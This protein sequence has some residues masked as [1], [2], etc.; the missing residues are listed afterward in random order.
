MASEKTIEERLG[1]LRAVITSHNFHYYV[2]DAP[3]IQDAEYDLIFR[4]LQQL[5]QQYPHLIT[6]DSPT[7]RVGAPPLKAFAQLAHE[8]PMLSLANAFSDEEVI[9]FDRR[10]REA[11]D[12]KK[13]DYAV[14]PKFDGLAVSLMYENGMLVRGATRGNGYT[15]EDITLNLRTISSIPLRLPVVPARSRFEVRGEVVMLKADF[16]QL[17]QRQQQKGEKIF[18]NPRNAAAGSLR[19]LDSRVTATRKLTFFAYDIGMLRNHQPDFLEHSAV[20]AYLASQQ[21]RVAQQNRIVTGADALLACYHEMAASRSTLPYEID[22]V[23][24]KVN[25]LAQQETLGYVSRAPRFAIAHKFPAQEASTELLAI[26]IQ[27]G[28]TGALTPVARLAPVFVGGVTVTNATLHNEDEIQRKQIMIGDTVIV[29]RAGD[30]IP[31]VVAAIPEHRPADAQSFVMPD[32]CPICDSRAV[33]LPGEAVTRCTGGLYCPAQRKQALWHFASRSAMDIDGLGEKLIDQLVERK[34]V[35]TPADLYKLDV[36]TLAK[37]ERMAEKSAHNLVTA[38]ERSKHTTLSRFIYALGIR[39]VGEATA[40]ALASHAGELNVLMKMRAD[41][42][43][44]IPDI[45]P[46]VAQS[47]EDFFI[48]AHNRDVIAQLIQH[49]LQWKKT[50]PAAQATSESGLI[51]SG[52]TFV[53][54]GTLSTMTR[55]QAKNRIEQQGGKVTASVSSVTSYVVVGT[56]PGSKYTRATELGIPVLDEDQLLSLLQKQSE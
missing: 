14:E 19:Q 12:V 35:H 53:L 34:L 56:D 20:L 49:G 16:E 17:N 50:P 51:F 15:G 1:A 55:E 26:E 13:V 37:L 18:V 45:G 6:P 41:E 40:K 21:F 46:V 42:L 47:I 32:H 54:T 38:I 31:E 39:H 2:Q 44:Q 33:R 24:Y 48:E 23:V 27:V 8:T 29:R 5:E 36:E 28:R 11:L 7:Q 9:A 10:V 3:V 52:K 4:E 25:N 30:V 43:Q 22:G